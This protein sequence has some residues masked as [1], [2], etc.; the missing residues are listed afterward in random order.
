MYIILR[1][2]IGFR[3]I[4]TCMWITHVR[5]RYV[6]HMWM[7]YA[8]SETSAMNVYADVSDSHVHNPM[9]S[10][11]IHVYIYIYMNKTIIH[12]WIRHIIYMWMRHVICD[13]SAMNIYADALGR[14]YLYPI[15][16][17]IPIYRSLVHVS[18]SRLHIYGSLLLMDCLYVCEWDVRLIIH[19][20]RSFGLK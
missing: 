2:V 8:M 10:H 5:I 11:R 16:L 18:K 15:Y 14:F 9:I 20:R 6:M 12:M 7:R 19:S 17:Y 13:T 3:Y 1:H 4:Y